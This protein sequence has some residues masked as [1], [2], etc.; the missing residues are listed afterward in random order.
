VFKTGQKHRFLTLNS[1]YIRGFLIIVDKPYS[2]QG[3]FLLPR[4]DD[5]DYKRSLR[6]KY[7]KE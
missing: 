7:A 5:T 4:S 1:A 3:T 6:W 2:M